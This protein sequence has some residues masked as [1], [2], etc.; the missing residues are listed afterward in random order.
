MIRS[1]APSRRYWILPVTA[2]AV[3]ALAGTALFAGPTTAPAT[4][5]ATAPADTGPA[6]PSKNKGWISGVVTDP[7]G[8]PVVGLEIRAEKN[9]PKTMGGGGG[10]PPSQKT[11]KAVTDENGK[12]TLKELDVKDYMLVAGSNEVGWIYQD[13]NVEAAKVT[14]VGTLKLTKI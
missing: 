14:D 2:L 11:W 9:E 12:F 6:K 5:P 7:D 4:G 13:V 8:K 10:G 3:L 1:N